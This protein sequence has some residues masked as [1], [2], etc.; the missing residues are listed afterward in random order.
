MSDMDLQDWVREDVVA[1]QA[2][3]V[4]VAWF[5][6]HARPWHHQFTVITV[7]H[8]GTQYDVRIDRLGREDGSAKS[9]KQEVNITLAEPLDRFL[10]END[11]LLA[12]VDETNSLSALAEPFDDDADLH[13]VLTPAFMKNFSRSA[14]RKQKSRERKLWKGKSIYDTEDTSHT[15]P[16]ATL[17]QIADI[18]HIIT[19]AA[20]KYGVFSSNCY[21]FSRLLIWAIALRH[22]AHPV[23][24][25]Q[26]NLLA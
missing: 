21:F 4:S 25:C 5:S 23:L 1:A 2:V 10:S 19:C 16:P 12:F 17:S 26:F 8:Q 14:L 3:T 6:S 13:T 9:A 20:P 11:L 15:G 24:V 22:Y 18:I 7:E